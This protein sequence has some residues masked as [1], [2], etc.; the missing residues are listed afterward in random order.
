MSGNNTFK[1][2]KKLINAII[3]GMQE[4]KGEKITS[5]NL[6][7]IHNAVCDYFI[8]CHG[9]SNT[10]VDAISGSIEEQVKKEMG[11]KPWQKEG[12]DNSE[13]VLLDYVNVVVHI[14]QKETRL[15]YNIEELWAD[16]EIILIEE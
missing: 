1:S 14:F 9:N 4:K 13:W 15:F 11:E 8:I 6:L 12:F 7:K 16:A 10:Q 3:T 2:T 5:L